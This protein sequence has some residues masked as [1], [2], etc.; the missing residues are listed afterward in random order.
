MID[1]SGFPRD[2]R[3]CGWWHLNGPE[4]GYPSLQEELSCDYAIVGAG[5]T[6]LAAA[7]RLSNRLPD[8]SI[9][10]ID[11]GRIGFGA[12]GRNSGFLYDLPFVFPEDAYRGREEDG[13]QEIALY[14][15]AIGHLRAFVRDHEV[16]LRLVRNRPIPRR[17]RSL[18]ESAISRPSGVRSAIWRSH[19]DRWTRPS[20]L[21]RWAR[22]TTAA[23]SIPRGRFRST[24]SLWFAPIPGVSRRTSAFTS[25]RR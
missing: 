15:Q 19:T 25:S 3:D 5:W 7:H 4:A 22:I 13:R 18:G 17:R 11:A 9:A 21:T 23:R 24:R 1:V 10:V 8:A 16:G 20:G 12:A 2:D 6:G 14:R